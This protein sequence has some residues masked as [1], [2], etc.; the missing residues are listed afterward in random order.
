MPRTQKC[1]SSQRARSDSRVCVA[2]DADFHSLLAT[3]RESGP[4][5]IRIRKEG[6]D[7]T[8]LA[9]FPQAIWPRFE[10][11]LNSGAL[12]TVTERSLR[13]RRLPIVRL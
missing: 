4:S 6:L 3:G 11:A 8:A 10:E 5:V 12:V 7:A 2:L 13:I 9:T 1:C